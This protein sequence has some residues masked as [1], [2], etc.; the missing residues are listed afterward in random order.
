MYDGQ[1]LDFHFVQV[2]CACNIINSAFFFFTSL[3]FASFLSCLYIFVL[4]VPATSFG[5]HL[6]LQTF[7]PLPIAWAQTHLLIKHIKSLRNKTNNIKSE[8]K[9]KTNEWKWIKW[10]SP[11]C[12]IQCTLYSLMHPMKNRLIDKIIHSLHGEI[13]C[14][15]APVLGCSLR[16][17]TPIVSKQ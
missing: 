7:S 6:S 11:P 4:C 1:I 14:H 17:S 10:K 12:P 16:W 9:R 15:I 8:M 13:V 3:H 2:W 5:C